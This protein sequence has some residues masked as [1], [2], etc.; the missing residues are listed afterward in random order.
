ME[1]QIH[2]CHVSYIY[3]RTLIDW[4]NDQWSIKLTIQASMTW[5]LEPSNVL[6]R[7]LQEK[8][9]C[10][11]PRQNRFRAPKARWLQRS[12]YFTSEQLDA[13]EAVGYTV[14]SIYETWAFEETGVQFGPMIRS[15]MIEKIRATKWSKLGL[16]HASDDEK[17]AFMDKLCT[18][19][20][21]PVSLPRCLS[22]IYIQFLLCR[23]MK[24]R[25]L[26][27]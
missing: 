15:L 17:R 6:S 25:T 16:A 1:L 4:L 13:A 18:Q 9:F 24:D 11:F 10:V 27:I 19:L 7:T 26:V 12:G 20:R 2:Q 22:H 3:D 5:E 8:I 21:I 23:S 14:H